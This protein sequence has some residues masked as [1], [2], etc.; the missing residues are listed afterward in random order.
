MTFYAELNRTLTRANKHDC[1]LLLSDFNARVGSNKSM[2]T[3]AMGKFGCGNMN[4]NGKLLL[5]LCNDFELAVTSTSYNMAAH[6]YFSWQHPWF[7]HG[8]LLDYVIILAKHLKSVC[9]T[10]AMWGTDCSSDHILICSKLKVQPY[11]HFRTKKPMT[12]KHLDVAKLNNYEVR[13]ALQKKIW[14]TLCLSTR[15]HCWSHVDPFQNKCHSGC[16]W[17][18][19]LQGKAKCRLVQGQWWSGGTA[20]E[21]KETWS[22]MSSLRPKG[23]MTSSPV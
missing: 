18:P 5:S 14:W 2:W 11:K 20:A 13:Q 8:H 23:W 6:H 21:R 19:G 15:R 12:Y 4:A 3:T 16:M 22:L 7:K 1:I 10:R 9:I 17:N